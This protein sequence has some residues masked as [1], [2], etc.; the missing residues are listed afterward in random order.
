MYTYVCM[1]IVYIYIYIHTR[2]SD[3]DRRDTHAAAMSRAPV[4]C[5]EQGGRGEAKETLAT[6]QV[7][8]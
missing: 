7:L 2:M 3:L 6:S 1:H 5:R 4:G 8:T